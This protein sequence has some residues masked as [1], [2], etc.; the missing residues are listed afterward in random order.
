M[1]IT[2]KEISK[3]LNEFA[4]FLEIKGENVYK[5]RAYENAAR[6]LTS[7][8][9]ELKLL[10]QE[11]RLTEI[12]GVGEGIASAIDEVFRT[13]TLEELEELK[14]ELP[15][16]IIDLLQ[17]PGLGPK[18]AHQL[19]YKLEINNVED[20]GRALEA[21]R[22]RELDGFGEKLEKKLIEGVARFRRFQDFYSIDEAEA[23][24]SEL[25]G[26]I[27]E[28]SDLVDNFKEVG[29]FRRKKELV[30]DIDILVCPASGKKEKFIEMLLEDERLKRKEDNSRNEDLLSCEWQGG[31][32]VEF[33]FANRENYPV[34]LQRATGSEEHSRKLENLAEDKGLTFCGNGM[35]NSEGE[36]IILED[37]EDLYQRLGLKF[38]IPELRED[39]GEI[40]AAAEN[41]LPD[42]PGI[43]D[44][45]GDLHVHS[46]Y[47]DGTHSLRD[48]TE[49]AV[50]RGYEY[51]AITDHSVSLRIADGLSAEDLAAQ[52]EDIDKIQDDFSDI[53][54][55]K[56]VEVDILPSGELD[57]DDSV[58]GQLDFVIASIHSNFS[59]SEQEMTE[60]IIKALRNPHVDI[61]GHPQG[62]LLA[63]RRAYSAN[64]EEIIEEAAST[65]TC[66]EI[67]A[68]PS[69]LD[70]DDEHTRRAVKAGVKVA[71]NT[72]AHHTGEFSSIKYGVN[73]ARRGWL[74]SEDIINTF[75]IDKLLQFLEEDY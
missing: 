40:E 63:S 66:L 7:L 24:F 65:G 59:Q 41:N 68:S 33:V 55:L 22:V 4:D 16:G 34:A 23:I 45:K 57:Y 29:S 15:D 35:E 13:G 20:L 39:K 17:I 11:D 5:I 47:S 19:F 54:I 32:D 61:L 53:K 58:L 10:W 9:E 8:E 71:I 50:R 3:L 62:R 67:N 26:L 73:I 27:E 74:S 60:R 72:D 6:R 48:M 75:S 1:D 28:H 12:D 43:D 51:I 70:L 25:S 52:S 14:R 56:G 69:R 49:M 21:G 30:R 64:M 2:S 38:I 36:D 37:E 42:S 18:R 46:R 44:I 31:F